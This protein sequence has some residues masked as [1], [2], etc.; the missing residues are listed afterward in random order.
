MRSSPAPIKS[1]EV[2]SLTATC[3]PDRGHGLHDELCGGE[4]RQEEGQRRRAL[5]AHFCDPTMCVAATASVVTV[6]TSSDLWGEELAAGEV[7]VRAPGA[8]GAEAGGEGHLGGGADRGAGAAGD[9]AG[10]GEVA[11]AALGGGVVGRD[12]GLAL[13]GEQL[14]EVADDPGAERASGAAASI[15][16]RA[17]ESRRASKPRAGAARR[18]SASQAVAKATASR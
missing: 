9:L 15:P 11:E 16:R 7:G 13:D 2:R 1:H 12:A 3:S 8:P 4:G 14:A 18:S 10:G 17:M 5:N 6:G